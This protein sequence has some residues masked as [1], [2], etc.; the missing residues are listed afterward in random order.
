MRNSRI[1]ADD[2]I[3]LADNR[4][5]LQ[6]ISASSKID[7]HAVSLVLYRNPGEQI[8]LGWRPD[9]NDRAILSFEQQFSEPGI[10]IEAPIAKA[11][12]AHRSHDDTFRRRRQ[13]V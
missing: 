7:D 13:N 8:T 10:I 12:V 6:P 11:R 1:V 9:K 4:D 3:S 5:R 2:E